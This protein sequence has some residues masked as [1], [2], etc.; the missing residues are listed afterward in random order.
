MLTLSFVNTKAE[1]SSSFS[2]AFFVG[3]GSVFSVLSSVSSV[4]LPMR[5]RSERELLPLLSFS[6]LSSLL[7]SC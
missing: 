3:H 5:C 2:N 6:S 4:V 7:S 1:K